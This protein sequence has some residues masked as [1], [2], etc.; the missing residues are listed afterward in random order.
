MEQALGTGKARRASTHLGHELDPATS[1]IVNGVQLLQ[2]GRATG[3]GEA[4]LAQGRRQ[5]SESQVQC[6]R[7]QPQLSCVLGG[8]AAQRVTCMAPQEQWG[9]PTPYLPQPAQ[10]LLKPALL[11]EAAEL[12]RDVEPHLGVVS[13]IAYKGKRLIGLQRVRARGSRKDPRQR[14]FPLRLAPQK[15]VILAGPHQQPALLWPN[16]HRGA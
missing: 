3:Q 8:K 11:Q 10:V 16:S 4:V 15:G 9:A 14:G 2:E 5:V 13:H 1:G 12:S 6:F 7:A